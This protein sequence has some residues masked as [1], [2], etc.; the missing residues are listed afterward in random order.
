M[1]HCFKGIGQMTRISSLFKTCSPCSS[2]E[3]VT[4]PRGTYIIEKGIILFIY[5]NPLEI[6]HVPKLSCNILQFLRE[7]YSFYI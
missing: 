2:N 7:T 1:D 4:I 3:K 5:F 6:C